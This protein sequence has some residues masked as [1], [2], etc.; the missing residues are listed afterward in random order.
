MAGIKAHLPGPGL[1]RQ[2]LSRGHL[3][4]ALSKAWA[5]PALFP[6]ASLPTLTC[7]FSELLLKVKVT[8][9]CPTLCDPV[10]CS[11]WNSPG[12]NTRVGNLSLLQGVFQTQ[13]SNPGLPHRR[14]ILYQLSYQGSTLTTWLVSAAPLSMTVFFHLSPVAALP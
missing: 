5:Y 12:Q 4:H 13:G 6:E 3:G 8:Q 11:P 14:R 2:P 9:S 1:S 10:D 7:L